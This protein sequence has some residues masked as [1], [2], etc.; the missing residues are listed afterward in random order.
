MEVE[1]IK[2]TLKAPG[3]EY[4]KLEYDKLLSTF[5]FTFNLR[6]FSLAPS[7]WLKLDVGVGVDIAP[8]PGSVNGSTAVVMTPLQASGA[9]TVPVGPA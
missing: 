4:L 2:H 6:R 7:Q 3:P 1:T 8:T 9:C 5:S